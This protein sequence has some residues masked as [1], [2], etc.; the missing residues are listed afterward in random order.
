MNTKEFI[1][2]ACSEPSQAAPLLERKGELCNN[3][4]ELRFRR[5]YYHHQWDL[6]IK[7]AMLAIDMNKQQLF[8][9]YSNGQLEELSCGKEKRSTVKKASRISHNF[10]GFL[11][12][13]SFL[14]LN[15]LYI[16]VAD[17]GARC[18]KYVSPDGCGTFAGTCDH[19]S[20]K[21]IGHTKGG[22]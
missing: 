12:I 11:T 13:S 2:F 3:T 10:E 8:R 6:N 14:Q 7:G 22:C 18:I 17:S 20:S 5:V 1:Y 4:E 9:I 16:L 19:F 21:G 15:R